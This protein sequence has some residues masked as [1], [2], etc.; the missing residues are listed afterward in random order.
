MVAVFVLCWLPFYILNIINLLGVLPGDFRW[1]YF[2][3]V[4]LSYANSCA[5]PILYGF[6][7]D[8]FKRGFQKALCRSSRRVE[9]HERLGTELQ[10][11]TEE[12]AGIA[13][14]PQNGQGVIDGHKG[15]GDE[16]EEELEGVEDATQMTEICRIAQNGN[17]ER[18]VEGSK[19]LFSQGGNSASTPQRQSVKPGEMTGKGPGFGPTETVSTLAKTARSG[20]N[21]SLAEESMDKSTV[22]EI[23]YL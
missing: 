12:W 15:D 4:V 20:S 23:S 21:R 10:R 2:F 18:V 17:T 7:S 5:N 8:N 22:L 1:L 11:P 16:D 9:N 6:L 3:V 19:T 13:R 14:E